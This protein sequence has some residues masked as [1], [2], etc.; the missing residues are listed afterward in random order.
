MGQIIGQG[1]NK[2]HRFWQVSIDFYKFDFKRGISALK[3]V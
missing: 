2:G 1:V 3:Y